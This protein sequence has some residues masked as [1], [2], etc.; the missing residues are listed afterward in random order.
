MTF[1]K[2]VIKYIILFKCHFKTRHCFLTKRIRKAYKN[3]PVQS[4]TRL[5]NHRRV[6]IIIAVPYEALSQAV[7][8]YY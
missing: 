1:N 2:F 5:K 7:T 6:K 3:L 8:Q 4:G